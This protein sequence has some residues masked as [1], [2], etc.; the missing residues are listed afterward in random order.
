MQS[1]NQSYYYVCCPHC[2]TTLA[3]A[4]NGMNG[5]IKCSKCNNYI[6]VIIRNGT[7]VAKTKG[8]ESNANT[9]K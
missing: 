4:K 3:Q 2:N 9:H 6:H 8:T 1:N 7:V 5:Y